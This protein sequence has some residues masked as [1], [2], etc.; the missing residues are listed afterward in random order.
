MDSEAVDLEVNRRCDK[1]TLLLLKHG[2]IETPYQGMDRV[3]MA[4]QEGEFLSFLTNHRCHACEKLCK[5]FRAICSHNRCCC[6]AGF[7][8]AVWG[9]C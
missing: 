7:S 2:A 8:I 9:G 3:E 4:V 5:V 6:Q 1:L